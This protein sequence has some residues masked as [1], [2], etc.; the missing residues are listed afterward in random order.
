MNDAFNLISMASF[1]N[2][3][4]PVK[5]VRVT[6]HRTANRELLT[7]YNNCSI[8]ALTGSLLLLPLISLFLWKANIY[9]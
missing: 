9:L 3:K 4:P 1:Q 8:A 2:A 7:N 6:Q 5:F